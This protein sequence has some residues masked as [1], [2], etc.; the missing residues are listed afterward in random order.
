MNGVA[1]TFYPDT[2]RPDLAE[3][4]VTMN[5]QDPYRLSPSQAL[6]GAAV[7]G[8][9]GLFFLSSFLS[10]ERSSPVE[11]LVVLPALFYGF[12]CAKSLA[13]IVVSA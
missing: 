5:A 1:M 3:A 13:R 10:S 7:N 2:E 11:Y 12:E 9:I 6:P 8:L 4:V